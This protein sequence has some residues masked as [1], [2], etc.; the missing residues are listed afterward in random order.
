MICHPFTAEPYCTVSRARR[1]IAALFV[2]GALFNIPKFFE[3]K[4]VAIHMPHHNGTR[5]GCDLTKF[6]RSHIFR[7]LYHSWF[8]IAF[9]CGVPFITLAVLNSCLMH[10][11][12]LSRLRGRELN[13]AEKKRNDT[14]V[15]LIGVVVTFFICQ[16]P[17]L[18]SRTIWAFEQNPTAFKR[19]PLYTL[20]EVGNLLIV[21]NSSINIVPYY[22]FGRRFRKQFLNL[23]CSCLLQYKR[24]R[25]FSRSFSQTGAPDPDPTHRPSRGSN[26]TAQLLVTVD[27]K[28]D[29][30][31]RDGVDS[32]KVE[33]QTLTFHP[34][35]QQS[36]DCSSQANGNCVSAPG[37]ATTRSSASLLLGPGAVV[38]RN[39][40][41]DL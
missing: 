14:T 27:E 34:S 22:F 3:Y 33:L 32:A 28:G 40:Q 13:M 20:N 15:M 7:E 9:V 36:S 18:V 37:D 5:I 17:A 24:F 8:Y 31:G 30:G 19:M 39:G 6:G 26:R 12:R 1:V 25:K 10:A 29:G 11:V 41:V 2:A 16:M 21:L 23:F 4:T 35:S 38:N